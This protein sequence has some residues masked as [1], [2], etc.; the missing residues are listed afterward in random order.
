MGATLSHPKKI[1][2]IDRKS[3]IE[4]GQG[5]AGRAWRGGPGSWGPDLCRL[6]GPGER[7]VEGSP[8]IILFCYLFFYF[9]LLEIFLLWIS[10]LYK[11]NV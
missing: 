2:I 5:R 11:G 8:N 10:A 3:C 7:G 9:I 4:T 1:T 6:V